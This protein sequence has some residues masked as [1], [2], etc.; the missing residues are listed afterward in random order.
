MLL[1]QVSPLGAIITEIVVVALIAALIYISLK[2]AFRL[3][4][5]S[6]LGLLAL[7]LFNTIFGL[8]IPYSLAVI[9]VTAI[10]G[11][12]AVFVLVILKVLGV[13]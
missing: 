12:P 5:N 11:L 4:A 10:F 2:F 7:F 6:V 13:F 8:G 3:I 1:L 9:V